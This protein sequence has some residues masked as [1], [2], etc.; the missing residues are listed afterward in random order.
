LADG[1]G[2][3]I[4]DL[5]RDDLHYARWLLSRDWFEQKY[6]DEALALALATERY[7]EERQAA[8]QAWQAELEERRRQ[9]REEWL[10]ACK[11]KYVQHGVMP[12]GKFRGQSLAAVVR[13][14]RYYRWFKGSLYPQ[15]NP[16]LATDFEDAA[17]RIIKGKI[18]VEI[19]ISE[20]RLIYRPASFQT[21]RSPAELSPQ[22]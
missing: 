16:E 17:A 3:S 11:V 13:A 5:A 14:E 9:N 1:K 12:F 10:V 22:D 4:G 7:E 19:E 18:A 2:R 6:P 15:A 8:L 20:G 21:A